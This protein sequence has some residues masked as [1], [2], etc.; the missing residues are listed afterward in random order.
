MHINPIQKHRFITLKHSHLPTTDTDNRLSNIS[1]S[2]PE[3]HRYHKTS[4]IS[5]G[6][7]S[8]LSNLGIGNS[9][10]FGIGK[11]SVSIFWCP[12]CIGISI[13]LHPIGIG[14]KVQYS[15]FWYRRKTNTHT[16]MLVLYLIKRLGKTNPPFLP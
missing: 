7:I 11:K 12:S 3:F 4:G 14:M 16:S 15:V 5:F 8:Y 9:N 10:I 6:I 13:D 1:H 2:D